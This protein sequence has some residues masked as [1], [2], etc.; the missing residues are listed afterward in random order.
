MHAGATACWTPAS[1][2][3]EIEAGQVGAT[4]T[5]ASIVIVCVWVAL[6]PA[7]SLCACQ[8]KLASPSSAPAVKS[9]DA[10][11]PVSEPRAG[12]ESIT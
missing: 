2:A 12:G 6:S 11:E 8:V 3:T 7:A 10:P 9:R 5:P 4:L 1:A